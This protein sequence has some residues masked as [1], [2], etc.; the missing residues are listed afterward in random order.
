[1]KLVNSHNLNWIFRSWP[2]KQRF[3]CLSTS[4][5]LLFDY[6]SELLSKAALYII[7][8]VLV[9]IM[10]PL[11]RTGTIYDRSRLFRAIQLPFGSS[12]ECWEMPSIRIW[13][14]VFWI[15]SWFAS[16]SIFQLKYGE[17]LKIR[18]LLILYSSSHSQDRRHICQSNVQYNKTVQP[19]SY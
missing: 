2:R 18:V 3:S 5:H 4:P 14:K 10:F 11:F 15:M 16:C 7:C 13:F 12:F 6:I 19:S 9:E 1:M 17:V 8:Y